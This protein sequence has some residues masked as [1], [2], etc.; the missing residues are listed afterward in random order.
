MKKIVEVEWLDAASGRGWCTAA[1]AVGEDSGLSHVTSIG[2]LV[3]QDKL[4]VSISTSWDDGGK[5]MDVLSIPR[6]AIT[7]MKVRKA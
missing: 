3:A 7:E 1:Q 2:F 4:S 5:F 6:A